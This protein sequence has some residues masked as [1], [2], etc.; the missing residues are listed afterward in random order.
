M[1]GYLS[2]LAVLVALLPG[3]AQAQT[4][5]DSSTARLERALTRQMRVA[6][7]ASGA[8]VADAES[9]RQLFAWRASS[10]RM[11]ASNTKLFTTAALLDRFGAAGTLE[12]AVEGTGSLAAD[13]TWQG[14][15]YLRGGGDP[16]LGDAA[17]NRSHY[18]D[19]ADAEE[20]ADELVQAGVDR[21]RGR[22]IGDETLFDSLRGGPASGHGV[23]RDVGPLSA[24]SY[25]RNRAGAGFVA[26]PP[27]S[28]ALRF[29]DALKRQGISASTSR[30]GVGQ[31]PPDAA[32]LA[33]VESPPMSR[34]VQITNVRSDNFFA[35]VLI[36]R[37]VAAGGGAGSTRQGA[38]RAAALGRRLGAAPRLA[39]GSGLSR[40]N[41]DSPRHVVELLRST[42]DRPGWRDSLA[43]AGQSGTLADRMRRGPARGVCRGKTGTLAGVSNLSGYCETRSG[44]TVAFSFLMSAV[45]VTGA[46]RLQDR[47]AEA[48]V[49]HAP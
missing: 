9:G 4:G 1:R 12:T 13:G 17:F 5:P 23:S 2:L 49:R 38:R 40:A 22:V 27:G 34:L 26:N 39:D 10:Y 7:P 14:D 31:A 30:T 20:L 44:S 29:V 46:R 37:L 19:A 11:L 28:A 36:K 33:E 43:V 45:S 16:T 25:N 35:E 6:G 3:A 18:G 15:L 24:L 48:L 47:M 41:R 32:P 42:R 8:F 21:L